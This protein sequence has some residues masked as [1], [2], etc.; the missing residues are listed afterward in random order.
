MF[1]L[2]ENRK[3]AL[4][5]IVRTGKTNHTRAQIINEIVKEHP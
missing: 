1:G 3:P 5:K 4:A 2:F